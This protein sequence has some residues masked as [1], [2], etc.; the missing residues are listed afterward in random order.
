MHFWGWSLSLWGS[1]G[2][3]LPRHLPQRHCNKRIEQLNGTNTIWRTTNTGGI[4]YC[5]TFTLAHPLGLTMVVLPTTPHPHCPLHYILTGNCN[6]PTL[7]VWPTA[8]HPHWQYDPLPISTRAIWPH[9]PWPTVL[10]SGSIY[11][12]SHHCPLHTGSMTY[13]TPFTLAVITHCNT[14][15]WPTAHI[16]TGSMTYCTTPTLA[17]WPTAHIHTGSIIHCPHPHWQ[18]DLLHNTH[19]GSVTYCSYPHWQYYPLPT[20]T[21][22]VWPTAHIHTG[23]IVHCPHPHWQYDLLHNWQYDLLPISTLAVWP[24]APYTASVN[25]MQ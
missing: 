7:A 16:H 1:V 10:H 6:T 5:T 11:Y 22:A 17:V 8:P 25:V 2:V 12:L 9:P 20:S 19:T 18:Y 21:L 13:C 23:S 3:L 24:I 15:V 14:A 4:I